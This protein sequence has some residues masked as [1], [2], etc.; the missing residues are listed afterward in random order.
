MTATPIEDQSLQSGFRT[1]WLPTRATTLPKCPTQSRPEGDARRS[2]HPL[3]RDLGGGHSKWA[4]VGRERLE[5]P[6]Q[7]SAEGDARRSGH[8]Q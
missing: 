7:S 5:L 6:T 2:G 8:P 1:I 3:G 4:V